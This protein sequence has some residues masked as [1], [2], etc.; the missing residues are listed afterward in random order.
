LVSKFFSVKAQKVKDIVVMYHV[1]KLNH[2]PTY[3]W[4]FIVLL[5]LFALFILGYLVRL[6]IIKL[7]K[8]DVVP[9]EEEKLIIQYE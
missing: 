4:V 3:L 7:K 6:F 9:D 2:F 1:K 8:R 5:I